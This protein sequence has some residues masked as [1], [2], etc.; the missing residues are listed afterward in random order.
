MN[1][2]VALSYSKPSLQSCL[3]PSLPRMRHRRDSVFAM[4]PVPQGA[5]GLARKTLPSWNNRLRPQPRPSVPATQNFRGKT[6]AHGGK[7]LRKNLL[8]PTSSGRPGTFQQARVILP[9]S[10]ART[11]STARMP[12]QL[13]S[14]SSSSSPPGKTKQKGSS[15]PLTGI[16]HSAGGA[17]TSPGESE[18]GRVSAS[19]RAQRQRPHLGTYPKSRCLGPSQT[20]RVR[21]P[22]ASP[23]TCLND[24]T[25][26]HPGT[27]SSVR[28]TAA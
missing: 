28:I 2:E 4:D 19:Q 27:C 3:F 8:P 12:L 21:G 1:T 14:I 20:H 10:P 7:C 26:S 23:T 15:R 13:P 25:T 18:D 16:C 11:T 6:R 9:A 17:R 24:E 5:L 22:E